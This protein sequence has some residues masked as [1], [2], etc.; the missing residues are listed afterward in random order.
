MSFHGKLPIHDLLLKDQWPFL[1]SSF[2]CHAR[3]CI[4]SSRYKHSVCRIQL[5]KDSSAPFYTDPCGHLTDL[6]RISGPYRTRFPKDGLPLH[7]IV[8]TCGDTALIPVLL[9]LVSTA[10]RW[11]RGAISMSQ[12][13][14]APEMPGCGNS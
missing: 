11:I 7:T 4:F 10:A 3:W 2:R 14:A 1:H 12:D 8:R 5:F 9:C 6:E 13:A